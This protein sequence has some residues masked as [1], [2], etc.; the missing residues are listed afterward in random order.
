MGV[1][2]EPSIVETWPSL[3]YAEWKDTYD[4]LHMWTQVVGKIRL[5]LSPMVNHWWQV[6]L[7]VTPRGLTTS[8]IPHGDR[9]FEIQFD[10]VDHVLSV[11]TS[12]G[13]TRYMSL[14]PRTVAD[15]YRELM[16][17]LRALG[18]EVQIF[19]KPQEVPD[20][21]PFEQDTVHAS[22]DTDCANRFLRILVENDS[23][24]KE[25]RG[26]FIGKASPVMFYWGSFDLSMARFS[27]RR[28]P[29][30]PGADHIQREAGS[31]E[32]IC[33]GFWPGSGSLLAPAYYS[34]T[35]PEP[36]G[37]REAPVRPDGAHFDSQ[38]GEFILLYDDVRNAPNPR[39]AL[40]DFLQST[41]EAGADLGK[42]DRAALERQP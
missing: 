11:E 17:I 41:Y 26:R 30:R 13:A 39:A 31:H 35:H 29:E 5:T 15:F 18:M 33:A 8:P 28:A 36:P 37:L 32:Y 40:L 6:A 14:Y 9:T 20:P 19:T 25:F 24:F 12:D 4:T 42:W 1:S 38:M 3:P 34:Y 16:S 27:G 22:Y 7:Y 23:V 21:I 2:R 10:L